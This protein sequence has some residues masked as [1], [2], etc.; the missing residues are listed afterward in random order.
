LNLQHLAAKNPS[1]VAGFE[2]IVGDSQA[3]RLA[4]G[5]AQRAALRDVPVLILGE[6]GTGK[7]MFAR[8]VHAASRRRNGPFEAINCTALPRELLESELFGHVKGAFTG[9]GQA[10]QGAF[11]RA[12]GGTLFLDEVGECDPLLQT[13]LLRVL[14]PP[15]GKG[16]CHREYYPVGANRLAVSNVRVVAATNRDLVQEVR[17]HRFREDLYYRLAAITLRLPPLRER[18]RDVPLLAAA[19]LRQ[20]NEDVRS[21]EPGYQ[22]KSLSDAATE[23]VKR[24]A[25]PGNVRQLYNALLQAATMAE[26]AVIE[27]RDVAAAAG[28]GPGDPAPNALEH[29][30]GGGFDLTEHLKSIQRH[31]LWRAMDEA[32]GVKARAAQLLGLKNYQT[33][34]AQLQRLQVD[35]N[36]PT[37]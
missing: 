29:P 34:D 11:A 27:R 18:P 24:H 20:I 8:A 22:D 12:D 16:P 21:Q 36:S 17:G 9:A 25:W 14:Q 30:L 5:R 1:E 2:D 19:L 26:G 13:K 35:W 15:P 7:E 4:V 6:S 10:R 33:L 28:D 32:R 3:I 31:Y 37:P 23:F